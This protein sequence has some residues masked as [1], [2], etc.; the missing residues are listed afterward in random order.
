MFEGLSE[1]AIIYD[2]LGHA[3]MTVSGNGVAD[4]SALPDGFYLIHS[5]GHFH[6]MIKS[7]K[8]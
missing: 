2:L 6:K 5:D 1:E 8:Y 3:R 7:R 4:I